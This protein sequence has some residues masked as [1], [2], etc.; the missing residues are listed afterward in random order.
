MVLKKNPLSE[1]AVINPSVSPNSPESLARSAVEILILRL[2]HFSIADSMVKNSCS[3]STGLLRKPAH[4]L[5]S[6][7][8]SR[9]GIGFDDTRITLHLHSRTGS[10]WGPYVETRETQCRFNQDGARYFRLPRP[11]SKDTIPLDAEMSVRS[12]HYEHKVRPDVVVQCAEAI[13]RCVIEEIRL[14]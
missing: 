13:R 11:G 6:A 12:V 14:D 10:G 7:F 2:L 9:K 1:R 8:H 3:A 4:M 5:R